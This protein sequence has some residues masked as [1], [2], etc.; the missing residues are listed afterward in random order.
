MHPDWTRRGLGSRILEL[1]ENE[2]SA[3]GFRRFELGATLTGEPLYRERAHE[4]VAWLQRE[5]REGEAFA[6]S[7]DADSE[8]EEGKF[9]VWTV[10]EVVLMESETRR[11]GA[12][13]HEVARLPLG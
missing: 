8:G 9:F 5:M 6:A 11:D 1:C 13:Y 2:A 12:V 7:L 3:E 4:T 10:E